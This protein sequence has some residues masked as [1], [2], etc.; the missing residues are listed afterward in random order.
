MEIESNIPKIRVC[1]R[2]RP[3]T[4]KELTKSERD[5]VDVKGDDEVTIK[6]QKVKLD[7]TKYVEEHLFKFDLAFNET[8]NNSDVYRSAILP[9]VNFAI[10]G[11]KVS[12]FAYGQ[13]GSGKTYTMIGDSKNEGLYLLAARDL[14]KF[15]RSN[16]EGCHINVS[17][18]E[19]YCGKLY[20]LLNSRK[21]L[22][23][24]EDAKS[25][26]NI[27]GLKSFE[28]EDADKLFEVI[29][30]GNSVRVTS[31]T[32]KN[33]DSSR[34][35]AILQIYIM[36]NKKQ[37][38]LLSFIDLAGNERGADTY[39]HDSQTRIDG[40]E[41]SKSLLALKE[42][43]RALD[44][45][46]KH[47]PFRGSKLTMVLKD[48]FIGNC[49]TVMIG[50]IS[51]AISNCEYT[52]N[53]LRYAD[54]VK[55]LKKDKDARTQLNDELML[56]RQPN[57]IIKYNAKPEPEPVVPNVSTALFNNAKNIVGSNR[58]FKQ[59]TDNS[60]EL[61]PKNPVTNFLKTNSN[62]AK[63]I[64]PIETIQEKPL[65]AKN[66]KQPVKQSPAPIKVYDDEGENFSEDDIEDLHD[67]HQSLINMILEQE[68]ILIEKHRK[69]L[70]LM[71]NSSHIVS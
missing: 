68:E 22:H 17:Y 7:L 35:H 52:L 58:L 71:Q 50:N 18:F 48:S 6:E 11:G 40:A 39:D 21:K 1:I 16:N 62:F 31:T 19:I 25:N 26:I 12:C 70:K 56:P 30:Y 69:H 24:R 8:M 29:N 44:Q 20:D 45:D 67:R 51:P 46:K 47:V 28:V 59:G 57:N 4:K 37:K 23:A 36:Q 61:Q 53:T 66:V 42:C 41:I 64:R 60:P 13:T 10:K 32:G 63:K 33:M 2:K 43:I 49:K 55:E 9:I 34:S 14:F 3:L 65:F 15:I 38:G 5:I 27:V 54:R